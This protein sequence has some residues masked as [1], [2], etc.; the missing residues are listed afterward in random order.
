MFKA[1]PRPQSLALLYCASKQL[2][3]L[4]VKQWNDSQLL[5]STDKE[6]FT[7]H[8]AY[9]LDKCHTVVKEVITATSQRIMDE[10][11]HKIQQIANEEMQKVCEAKPFLDLT[12]CQDQMLQDFNQE[13]D[14]FDKQLEDQKP[15]TVKEETKSWL[16]S[17]TDSLL[18]ILTS[19]KD[20]LLSLFVRKPQ[21]QGSSASVQQPSV[22]I[23]NVQIVGAS[24][25]SVVSF[26]MYSSLAKKLPSAQVWKVFFGAVAAMMQTL[27]RV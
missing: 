19:L 4:S 8:Q 21:Q 5:F 22:V 10:V 11:G 7:N 25:I 23:N 12:I 27:L 24:V 6:G 2:N 1:T 16:R 18:S 17:I 9:L 13:M 14:P 3:V 26:V 15:T 20:K